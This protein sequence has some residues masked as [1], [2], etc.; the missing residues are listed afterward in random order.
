MILS[1]NFISSSHILTEYVA[2]LLHFK[3]DR[4]FFF[5]WETILEK[6]V[7]FFASLIDSCFIIW[8]Y[9]SC[10]VSGKGELL[11]YY[12]ICSSKTLFM[13]VRK[14]VSMPYLKTMKNIYFQTNMRV[15][16]ITPSRNR[17]I[18]CSMKC[19]FLSL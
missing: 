3:T 1:S 15:I 16:E 12:F 9:I 11:Y 2:W 8:F 17:I 19:F 5:N 6:R 13:K 18:K 7:C 10:G 14:S 4:P